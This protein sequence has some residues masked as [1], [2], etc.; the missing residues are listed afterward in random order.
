MQ[1]VLQEYM[2]DAHKLGWRRLGKL[3]RIAAV[4]LKQKGWIWGTP[5]RTS[6]K[7]NEYKNVGQK[8]N[9][10]QLPDF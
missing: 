6:L 9:E 3:C 2:G 7:R 4:W 8:R 1:G 5:G 10:G